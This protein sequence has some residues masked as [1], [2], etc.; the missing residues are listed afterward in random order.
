M[1]DIFSKGFGKMPKSVLLD[2][3][4]TATAKLVYAA[5]AC[6][7]DKSCVAFP[8][9]GRLMSE[10]S[11]GEEK[12]RKAI[13]SLKKAGKIAVKRARHNIYT[14]L[15][16]LE[17]GFSRVSKIVL[18]DK[19]LSEKAK[20][21]FVF[22]S[23]YA[24]F[25][26]GEYGSGGRTFPRRSQIMRCLGIRSEATYAKHFSALVKAG[27][28]EAYQRHEDGRFGVNDYFLPKT[29]KQNPQGEP[30]KKSIVF[31][32]TD[33]ESGKFKPQRIVEFVKNSGEKITR[34]VF[35]KGREIVGAGKKAFRKISAPL[36]KPQD[37]RFDYAV[38]EAQIRKNID[39]SGLKSYYV[40]RFETENAEILDSIVEVMTDCLRQEEPFKICKKE[41]PASR[42]HE[43]FLT[44]FSDVH[45]SCAVASI[46]KKFEEI[47]ESGGKIRNLKNY[48]I[49]VLYNAA[50]SGGIYAAGGGYGVYG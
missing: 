26:D 45:A 30:L 44:K 35:E 24:N 13:R 12:L 41:I 20:Q 27:Y 16:S 21:I 29:P 22:H 50:Q 48:L 39:Y 31:G 42:L 49:S 7:A 40:S 10:L 23:C 3:N 2:E 46:C 9:E 34:E 19:N 43:V 1:S 6:Y 11:I 18:T 15:G 25:S 5:L 4:L 28:V 38:L 36:A 37:E 33:S 17:N 47:S 8:S 32:K 14:L